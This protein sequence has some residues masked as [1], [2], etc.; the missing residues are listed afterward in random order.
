M[1]S[2][3]IYASLQ[4]TVAREFK[5]NYRLFHRGKQT[6]KKDRTAEEIA[7]KRGSRKPDYAG[8]S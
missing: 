5:K 1:T 4:L 8:F 3:E 6:G 7:G 2:S